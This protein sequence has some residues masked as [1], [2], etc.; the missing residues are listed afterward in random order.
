MLSLIWG[1]SFTL[2]KVAVETIPP[3]TMVTARTLVA[4]VLLLA[5]ARGIGFSVPRDRALWGAFFVQGLLQSAL[6]FA[7][8][9]WGEVHS[10]RTGRGA[11]R[12]ASALCAAVKFC[13]RKR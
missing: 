4:G 12:N 5:F 13:P 11:Q 2:I 1:S 10:K 6:P 3:L 7:L 8:I 9:S